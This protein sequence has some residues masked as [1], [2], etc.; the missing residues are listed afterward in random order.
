MKR[1]MKVEC[2]AKVQFQS[3]PPL[4]PDFPVLSAQVSWLAA[5]GDHSEQEETQ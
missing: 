2:W 3:I 5:A 1:V 4:I